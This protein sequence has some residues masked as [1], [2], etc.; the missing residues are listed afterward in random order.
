MHLLDKKE[1]NDRAE[2]LFDQVGLR[3]DQ[4]SLFPHQFS[5]GQRQRI[6]VARALASKPDLLVLDEPVSAL[7]VAIQAQLLNLFR[8]LKEQ[9]A[10]TYVFISHDLGVVQYLCDHIAVMYLGVIMESAPRASLFRSPQHPYTQAL[11]KA[12]PSI[13][14]M[15]QPIPLLKESTNQA[16]AINPPPGCRFENRCPHAMPVCRQ[17]MPKLT[18]VAPGHLVACH[19]HNGSTG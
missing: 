3:R 13:K 15:L 11:L 14:E 8:E 16:T 10:L 12:V 4:M 6:G 9:L 19:L 17:R 1:R 7:D 18:E 2:A 5:G